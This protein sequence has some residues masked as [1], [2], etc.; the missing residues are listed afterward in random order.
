MTASVAAGKRKWLLEENDFLNL[1]SQGA[2]LLA[3][4][5]LQVG[6]RRELLG[7]KRV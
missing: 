5:M 2:P 7:N 3:R 4:D 1:L 6:H